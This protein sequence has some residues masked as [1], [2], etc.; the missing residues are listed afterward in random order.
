[1]GSIIYFDR[2]A[3]SFEEALPLGGGKLGAMIYGGVEN[4]RISLNYDELWTGYPRNDNKDAYADFVRARELALSFKEKEAE[5]L[6]E[7]KICSPSVQSYQPAGYFLIKREAGEC[8]ARALKVFISPP[9]RIVAL[10]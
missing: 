10:L 9:R 7:E 5:K 4:D 2:P 8:P 6:I 3:D 1:M